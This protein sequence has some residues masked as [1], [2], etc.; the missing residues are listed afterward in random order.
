[1]VQ[2]LAEFDYVQS[3]RDEDNAPRSNYSVRTGFTDAVDYQPPNTI[4]DDDYIVLDQKKVPQNMIESIEQKMIKINRKLVKKF[5]TQAE[6]EKK[7][8]SEIETDKNGNVSVD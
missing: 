1:M 7:I 6:L 8:N 4:F 2:N 3:L 5:G